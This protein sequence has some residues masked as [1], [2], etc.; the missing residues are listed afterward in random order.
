[1][2]NDGMFDWSQPPKSGV[3]AKSDTTEEVCA[4]GNRGAGDDA[5]KDATK[6][7]D[8]DKAAANADGG[9]EG[10]RSSDRDKGDV[11]CG[12]DDAKEKGNAEGGNAKEEALAEEGRDPGNA[13]NLQPRKKQSWFFSIFKCGS[14]AAVKP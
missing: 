8:K 13:D 9:K 12:K 5:G 6:G 11:E 7:K 4:D 1:M 14:K 3:P 10:K 2:G